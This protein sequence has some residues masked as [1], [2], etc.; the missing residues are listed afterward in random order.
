VSDP[1]V[2]VAPD[3]TLIEETI[4]GWAFMR[5][6]LNKGRVTEHYDNPF[7]VPVVQTQQ[8]SSLSFGDNYDHR[9]FLR[10]VREEERALYT[11]FDS[12]IDQGGAEQGWKWLTS[13]R[14]ARIE[15]QQNYQELL[16]NLNATNAEMAS[17]LRFS[18]RTA[19]TVQAT[20][21]LALTC[22]GLLGVN[23]AAGAGLTASLS[24]SAAGMTVKVA[25]QKMAVG[26]ASGLTLNM[27][28][29]WDLAKP[30]DAWLFPINAVGAVGDGLKDFLQWRRTKSL[31]RVLQQLKS[32]KGGDAAGW[33]ARQTL[34]G[35]KALLSK[36][37]RGTGGVGVAA[38]G[39]AWIF[40]V[41][42]SYDS[43]KK[44]YDRFQ[45]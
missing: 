7:Y 36:P 14:K 21:E 41:K 32:V 24:M 23:V 33:E 20:A 44:L 11:L 30:S 3:P 27:I 31:E 38:T 35:E 13:A 28:D 12:A 17:A 4:H 18:L 42:S 43:M 22:L 2:V 19:A 15:M 34:L 9:T 5:V 40:A 29:R 10:W 6:L 26:I 39:L 37:I 1:L 45:I 25:L 16:N 8:P